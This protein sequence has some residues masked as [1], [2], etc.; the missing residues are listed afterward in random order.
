MNWMYANRYGELQSGQAEIV[1]ALVAIAE[2]L[3]RLN[4]NIEGAKNADGKIKVN[5]S[6]GINTHTY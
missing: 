3:E 1:E 4:Q 2:M 5:V 6:G